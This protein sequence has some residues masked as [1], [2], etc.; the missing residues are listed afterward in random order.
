[1]RLLANI[2]WASFG[3]LLGLDGIR[4][5]EDAPVTLTWQWLWPAWLLTP[6]CLAI[7]VLVVVMGRASVASRAGRVVTC[8]LRIAMVVLTFLLFS[9]PKLTLQR[10]RSERA[11]VAVLMDTSESMSLVD[12]D[13]S[14]LA[15]AVS[16]ITADSSSVLQTLVQN[17]DVTVYT[18]DETTKAVVRIERNGDVAPAVTSLEEL[19]PGGKT[20]D[21][22]DAM[23]VAMSRDAGRVAAVVLLSDGRQTGVV[24]SA[25]LASDAQSRRTPVHTVLLGSSAP[26]PDVFMGTIQTRDTV[27]LRDR[28]VVHVE[29]GSRGLTQP[30]R[31]RVSLFGEGADPILEQ[32]IVIDPDEASQRV[33]LAI[34]PTRTGILDLRVA[35][36]SLPGELIDE[37]NAA[38]IR[39]NVIDRHMSV[40]YVDG[41]PRYEYRYL[42]NAL[43]REPTIRSSCLLLSA[44]AGFAQE[45]TDP[46]DAFPDTASA[47]NAYDVVIL[48]DVDLQDR[49]LGPE[50]A[51]LIRDFVAQRGGGLIVMA[52]PTSMPFA[53]R[54]T[55]LESTLPVRLA[56]YDQGDGLVYGSPQPL[57]VTLDGEESALFHFAIDEPTTTAESWGGAYWVPPKLE[58]KAGA[59][60]LAERMTDL[61]RVPTIVQSRFGAGRVVYVATDETW[62]W[63]QEGRDW[64]FDAFWLQVCRSAAG[65]ASGQQGGNPVLTTDR[66]DYGLGDEVLVTLDAPP[67]DSGIMSDANPHV[68]CIDP[69][70]DVSNDVVLRGLGDEGRLFDGTFVPNQSG[71]WR[72]RLAGSVAETSFRVMDPGDEMRR[73]EAD[74]DLLQ[75]LSA[76]TGGQAVDIDGLGAL[77][78]GIPDRSIRIPDDV[79][80]P[81]WDSYLSFGLFG[82]LLSAEWI[83]RKAFGMV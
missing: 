33:S 51:T 54:G 75:A 73:P 4:I 80:E 24:A 44:D 43:L 17:N 40:L 64:S 61:G 78:A 58:P 47:V 2:S 9:Q 5:G 74:H 83:S 67:S 77:A 12:A 81:I 79:T 49:R 20:T 41:Y 50:T 72:V 69:S 29:V 56:A 19:R 76:K 45:G 11:H 46:I 1:M 31:A 36:E 82:L 42:K 16:A 7:C 35:I 48:G 38:S 8:G 13:R 6:I 57:R 15:A 68:L 65:P 37:N 10:E 70:G 25:T 71:T 28:A 39:M 59:V 30:K 34:T 55:A 62:R 26:R 63:R 52:G 60:I 18:F 14:R 32:F 23:R 22:S 53:A 21:L 27:F 66:G 3:W